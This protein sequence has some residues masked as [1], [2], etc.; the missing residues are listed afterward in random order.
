[1][2]PCRVPVS[3]RLSADP[4]IPFPPNVGAG[5]YGAVVDTGWMRER[6]EQYVE[7]CERYNASERSSGYNYTEAMRAIDQEAQTLQP[8]V[9]RILAALDPR[10]TEDLTPLGYEM[11]NIERRIRQALGILDD[12]DEWSVRLAPDSPNL[13]ADEMHPTVWAAAATVW[14]T[15]QYRVAVQQAAVAISA[16]IKSRADSHLHDRELVAQVFASDPPKTGQARLHL[17]GDR[18]DRMW[19]SRQQGLH[20]IAQGAFAGIRN[21]AVHDD[22]EWTEHEALEHLAVLSVVAR[23]ADETRLVQLK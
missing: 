11:S 23:W 1:M 7:L 17:P 6:L 18:A 14:G 22:L 12:R 2:A 16:Q 8:T 9:E 5:D 19:Q 13:S 3:R 10:L 15:G 20:L 21:V 4:R